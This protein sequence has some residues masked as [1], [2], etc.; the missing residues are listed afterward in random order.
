[1]RHDATTEPGD[2]EA[3]PTPRLM[4]LC[5]A[6]VSP[7]PVRWLWPGFLPLG[8]LVMIDGQ[9]GVG[10]STMI[11][12]GIARVTRGAAHPGSDTRFT[13]GT[14]FIAGAEDGLADTIRPRLDA[15]DADVRRV[16]F[17]TSTRPG[18]TLT[19]PRDTAA[20]RDL[21][22]EHRAVWLHFDSIMQV[23]DPEHVN[24]YS[25]GDVRRALAPLR[26]LAEVT[27]AC[28]SMTRHPRK[29]GGTAVTA[30]GGSIAFTALA[31]VVLTVG[32]DPHD[33]AE[34]PNERRR[35]VAVAKSNIGRY[36]GALAFRLVNSLNGMAHVSWDGT[37]QNVTADQLAAPEVVKVER[38]TD[39]APDRRS[40][41]IAFLEDL[42]KS[43][44]RVSTDTVKVRARAADLAWRTVHR[45]ADDLGVTKTREGFGGKGVWYLPTEN[46]TDAPDT[47]ATR[48]TPA[49][50]V[51]SLPLAIDIGDPGTNGTNGAHGGTTGVND[52]PLVR[53]T[54]DDG[55]SMTTA[56][57]DPDLSLFQPRI[58]DVVPI[59]R[60]AA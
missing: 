31:R 3:A 41:A 47:P 13:P 2:I 16:H 42:L 34:D 12:D 59:D 40:P 9:P 39:S 52:A 24:V 22:L 18:D 21:V 15:A 1:M 33:T 20:L 45:A 51:P 36:P 10:K 28:V 37:A 26:D 56:A 23:F 38:R 46:D 49:P 60:E 17:I 50:L 30:G 8:K 54:L 35:V 7:E 4:A 55:T 14:V 53:V 32:T 58:I 48:A 11:V 44:A 43:G 29:Q 5:A 27:G 6:D 19:L 57:N 25:D